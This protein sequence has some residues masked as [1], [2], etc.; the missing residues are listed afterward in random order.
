[1]IVICLFIL[2]S[3]SQ[4]TKDCNR[5]CQLIAEGDDYTALPELVS[6][7]KYNFT[8]FTSVHGQVVSKESGDNFK[9]DK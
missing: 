6:K 9:H 4:V 5:I 1:M 8:E 7:L 3:K 2:L